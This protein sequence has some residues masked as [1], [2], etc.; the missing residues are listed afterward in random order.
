LCSAKHLC[1]LERYAFL[2]LCF[3]ERYAYLD[4]QSQGATVSNGA[5]LLSVGAMQVGFFSYKNK[6]WPPTVAASR[7][8]LYRY[9]ISI[10]ITS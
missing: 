1:F 3:L 8:G 10:R 7:V 9:K 2:A 6:V 4:K 5:L